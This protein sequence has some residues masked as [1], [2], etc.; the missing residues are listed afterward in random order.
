MSGGGGGDNFGMMIIFFLIVLFVVW[1]Y[2]GGDQSNDAKKP[3]IKSYTDESA[4][5]KVYD[6]VKN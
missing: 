1:M 3:Y 2:T 6:K 5:L 4:P